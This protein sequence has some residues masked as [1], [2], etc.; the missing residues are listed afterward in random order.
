MGKELDAK[1]FLDKAF[2]AL[3]RTDDCSDK[4]T[5]HVNILINYAIIEYKA[6]GKIAKNKIEEALKIGTDMDL[7]A[8]SLNN[9]AM[10]VEDSGN[11]KYAISLYDQAIKIREKIQ[12]SIPSEYNLNC[13]AGYKINFAC[14]KKMKLK[15]FIQAKKIFKEALNILKSLPENP[16]NLNQQANILGNLAD[17]EMEFGHKKET[18]KLIEKALKIKSDA[19]TQANNYCFYANLH[20]VNGELKE[21]KYYFEKALHLL[22]NT[23]GNRNIQLLKGEIEK[24]LS[25]L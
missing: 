2:E 12:N 23:I 14:L 1:Q 6:D 24:A 20:R 17:I 10:L 4:C 5:L 3:E 8:D 13:I 21:A 7:L 25:S 16:K 19:F 9:Y 15:Q 18:N 11:I 22:N